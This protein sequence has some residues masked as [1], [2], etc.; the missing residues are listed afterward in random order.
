M[1]RNSIQSFKMLSQIISSITPNPLEQLLFPRHLCCLLLVIFSTFT[2]AI[3]IITYTTGSCRSICK[4][5]S[6]TFSYH[7]KGRKEKVIGD[8]FMFLVC[9]VNANNN[10]NVRTYFLHFNIDIGF[11]IV[12]YQQH[13]GYNLFREY[14]QLW[15]S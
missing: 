13:I 4:V 7:L 15:Y 8:V 3:L 12:R 1:H 9:L 6:V 14:E 10:N 11:Q 2:R 5:V